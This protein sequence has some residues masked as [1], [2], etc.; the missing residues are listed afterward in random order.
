MCVLRTGCNTATKTLEMSY[1]KFVPIGVPV[2]LRGEVVE[3]EGRMVSISMSLFAFENGKPGAE[4]CTAKGQFVALR[5]L[6]AS[7]LYL[8]DLLFSNPSE[9]LEVVPKEG[10]P[11]VRSRL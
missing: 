4:L 1:K 5:A 11:P 3:V 8:N 10:P 7:I 2:W 6:P 9:G